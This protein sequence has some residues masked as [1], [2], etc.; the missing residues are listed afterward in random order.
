MKSTICVTAQPLTINDRPSTTRPWAFCLA[1]GLCVLGLTA[2]AAT[3]YVDLNNSTPTAPY[4]NWATAATTIQAAVDAAAAG[5]EIV[6]TNGTYATGGK[7]VYGTMTNRVVID[8]AVTVRSVNGPLATSIAGQPAPGTTGNGDGAIRCVYLVANAVLSG[9]TLTNGHTHADGDYSGEQSGG[10]AWCGS[11]GVLTNCT[12]TA[13]SAYYGGG[14]YRGTLNNCTLTGNSAHY[15]GGASESTLNNCTLTANSAY[16]GGGACEGTLN[17]CTLTANS[18]EFGGGAYV[19]TLNNCTLT[20]NSATGEGGGASGG[21]LNNCTLTGNSASWYGGGASGGTLNNCTLTANSANTGGGAYVGA[22]N[23]CTL[24]ANSANTGGGAYVGTLYNCTLTGNSASRD[25]GGTSGSTLNNCTLTG[26]SAAYGSGGGAYRGTLTNCTLTGNSAWRDGG[27]ASGSTLNNCIVYYNTANIGANYFDATFAYSCTAPLPAGPGNI[28]ADPLLASATHLSAQSPCIGRGSATY[29]RGF[30]IDGEP[31]R[32]PPCMG[33]DQFVDGAATGALTVTIAA[34]YTNVAT[35]FALSFEAQLHGHLAANVWDFGDG[36]VV[37]NLPY[38]SHAW[39]EAGV[40]QV[41]LTGYN[42]SHP[43]GVSAT[44]LVRVDARE[45]YYVNGANSSP[46]YP[47]ARWAGAAAAIQEAIDAGTQIGRLVLVSDG[48]YA[49]GGRAVIGTMTNRVVLS[50]GVEVRSVNGPLVTSIAGQPAPGTTNNGDGAI[51]CVY[52][53]KNAM[54]SGFTLTNGHTLTWAQNRGWDDKELSGGGAWCESGGVLTNCTLTGNSAWNGGGAS[55][56]TLNNCTLTGNSATERGGGA[57]ECTLNNCTVTANSAEYGGGASG[58]TLN[59]C[60]LTAN[61]ADG[62]PYWGGGCGGGAS[63]GTL[64]HCTLTGNSAWECG[65]GASWGTL[66]NCTLT[67]NQARNGGGASWGTLNNCTLSSNSAAHYGGGACGGTLNNCTLTANSAGGG[68]GAAGDSEGERKVTLNNC[69]LRGNSAKY[70]GGVFGGTLNNCTLT[71]NSAESGGG[72]ADGPPS[73]SWSG[74]WRCT[75]N[76][77][78]LTVNSAE[79]GGG[80]SGSTLNNCIVYY[81]TANIGANYSGSTF[82]YSCT[83]PLP[84][85]PGNIDADPLLASAT[86]LSAQSPCIGRGSPEYTTGVDIDGEPWLDP[87]CMGADQFMAGPSTGPLTVTIVAAYTNVASG[88]A[89]SFVAHSTGP[90]SASTWDLGDG[91]VLTNLPYASRAWAEPGVYPVRLTGYNDSHPEGVSA[92][93]LVRVD[94]REVYYAN[95][96][97]AS[98]VYP[99]TSWAGAAAAIQEAIDAGTQIGRLVLVSDGVYASG[100]R[101]VFGTM[102]NRVVLSEGVEVRSANGPLVTSIAG[103]PAPGTTNN[104]NGAIRCVYVGKNA[105]LSGFTLSNGHTRTVGDSYTE[106]SGG[107]A[108]CESSGALTNCTLTVNSASLYGGG[109]FGGTLNNCTL[110]VNSAEYGG[111][112]YMGTLNNCTLTANSAES[113]GGV[114]ES[115]L[116]NCTLTANSASGWYGSGGGA[117]ASTLNNCTLTGNSAQSGGG[118]SGGTLNNCTLTANS[119]GSGGGAS[120]GM[121]NNCNLTANSASRDGGGAC[122]GTLNNCTLTANS[123]ALRGGG[124]AG[125]P[126]GE[127]IVALNNCTLTANSA[128]SGGGAYKGTL[129]NCIV[130]Y[131]TANIGANHSGSTFAYSCTMPLP[132]GPGNTD[133]DPLLLTATHLSAQS[134]CIGRGSATY[135][136]GC[137]IDGEPWLDPPCMGA[138]QF[139]AGPT[140]GPLTVTIVAAYTNVASGFAVSFVAHSTG[141]ISA[142]T[143]DFGD[144]VV[145]TNLPYASHAWAEAGVYPVRLTGYNHSHPEGVSAT[146]LVRVDARQVYYANG[147]NSSPVYPYTSWAGAAAAI[148]EA[149]DAGTQIGRLVLVSD[150]VYASGGRAVFGTMTMTNRLVLSEGVEVRSANGPLVTS[151]AGQPAPGTTNNGDGAIRCVYVG[152]NAMLSGFALT[153]GHTRADWEADVAERSGGGAWC[154]SSGVLTNCTL[155]GNS[156]LHYGGG[157]CGGTLNNCTLAG[158]SAGSGGGASGGTLNN[159]TLAGNYAGSSGGGA[160]EG[161]LNNCTLTANYAS[162]NGGGACES[163]LN[164]CSLT[165]NAVGYV[166]D[167]TGELVGSGGGASGGT[168]NNCTLTTNSSSRD[169]GGAYGSTLNNCTLA[170]NSAG[171]GGG[172]YGSTLN[173]CTLTGNSA[174]RHGGGACGGTLNNCTLAGNSAGGSGGAAYAGWLS[175]TS[176]PWTIDCTLNN[177]TL[178]GNSAQSGGG[179]SG[180]TLNNC[181]LAGNYAG[182]S[183][184]GACGGTLNNCTLTG[185]SAEYGGGA[186]GSAYG[187]TLNNCT[188]TANSATAGGGGVAVGTLNNCIVYH[189]TSSWEANYYESTFAYSCTTPLPEGPGNI[190]ADPRFVNAVAGDFRLRPDSPCIDTGTNLVD[191]I[192]TDI[193]GVPRPLDGDGDGIARFDMGAYEFDPGVLLRLS[194][195]LTPAGP[196]LEWPVTALGSKLQRTSSLTDPVWQDVLGS[197]TATTVTVPAVNATEFFRLMRP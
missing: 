120:G 52:V 98:P 12:L 45:V 18:A 168:L 171:S 146:V 75:L 42:D 116:N 127:V 72:A 85:G 21:T 128:E 15:G 110:T 107:G 79:Y 22:L 147:A 142:S 47:Y 173:N 197:E 38:A 149:I 23:N 188:L 164:N 56:G 113:G 169:G 175:W 64:N 194:V 26:N 14:A 39:A 122:G 17:N 59:N 140:T 101:A 103:Q 172:A 31:W 87:P 131:N 166:V 119:A 33:A 183:G 112:A 102:T 88:F 10:G 115:T 162:E 179:A 49:S 55:G 177:C 178:T 170:G 1:L 182:S 100:G 186:W 66:N 104:G 155:T 196:R 165:G 60:T 158:N 11:S 117:L 34:A 92:T 89:V 41:R 57:S 53:G 8:K 51:R 78:T 43:E 133:A 54:L 20:A 40:Y 174:S 37:S 144:G 67:A 137:D 187:G 24:T 190:D 94:A 111:G 13:N 76:H 97:N 135:A 19:G 167:G 154:E 141:P 163:T 16:Y 139:M 160:S 152:K 68:G 109:A 180:G 74:W 193:L 35:G 106:Q 28:D 48:V 73:W 32:D 184:G 7:A 2:S 118:A 77:C 84:S 189:N 99:Y 185:N 86:H 191:P 62:D 30:D 148:Q 71:A 5:D 108:W 61:W 6:V 65:G 126:E 93:V 105:V 58:G 151:I 129:N 181:T 192:A 96:A 3:R 9:F 82:A 121:L 4:T 157:A 134:P 143:W 156:A 195:A 161:T 36:V 80:A 153:N 114:Y 95:G 130:Y 50:E 29:A 25:G 150:G 91:V 46:V 81:N 145:L 124:A 63:G 90:I 159:C 83:T 176:W 27:G 123:A 70:G 136:R 69:T 44:V 138:D 125:D 132:A